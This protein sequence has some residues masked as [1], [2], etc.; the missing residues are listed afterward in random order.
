MYLV[1]YNINVA[2][3]QGKVACAGLNE[4]SAILY[5]YFILLAYVEKIVRPMVSRVLQY[6]RTTCMPVRG[7][8][9]GE[10]YST[11]THR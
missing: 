6:E 10:G 2:Q 7:S 11:L 8:R 5:Y 3:S 9:G 4:C 1:S